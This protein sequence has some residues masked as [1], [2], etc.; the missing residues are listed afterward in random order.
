MSR[1]KS[2]KAACKAVAE[3]P[4][5]ARVPERPLRTND[6]DCWLS[7]TNPLVGVSIRTAQAIFDAARAGDT[8]RL[9]WLYQEIEAKDPVLMTC[10]ERRSAAIA[11]FTWNVS[12][13][14][15]A[16]KVLADEQQSA[17]LELIGNITNF[18]ELLEHLDS[19]F[20]RGFALAQ[21]VWADDGKTLDMV[22]IHDSWEFLKKD[23]VLYWNPG[24]NGFGRD[25]VDCR[26]AGLIGVERNRAIDYPALAIYLRHAVSERDWGRF[27][28]RYALPKPAVT[29][30]PNATNAQRNDYL[31]A[32]RAVENGQVS[33][34]PSGSTI[35]D[36][37]GGSR[38]VDPFQ[39]FIRHQEELI[40]LLATG[41]TLTSL[42][43][44]D[45]G[46]LA[47]GAQMEVWKQIVNRDAGVLS[48]AV[49]LAIVRPFLERNFWG[50][51]VAADFGLTMPFKMTPQEAANVAATLKQAGWRVDQ[52]ELEKAVGFTLEREET[53]PQ[54]PMPGFGAA[55]KIVAAK[56][57][58]A[59]DVNA[60]IAEKDNVGL[61]EAF[62]ADMSPAADA[63]THLLNN[64]TKEA[65]EELIGK[66]GDLM[67]DDPAMAAILAEAMANEFVKEATHE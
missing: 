53:Q 63:I 6:A 15:N 41:G 60:R 65:A 16:D 49:Q 2:L 56:H 7:R 45:T 8:Q 28:E 11:N 27:L 30:A 31:V 61:L 23:G 1:K 24:C 52:D 58:N 37:A 5:P 32:A 19:S 40:V 57:P 64:P 48:Q 4:V 17:A 59:D 29:M 12:A 10:I 22:E 42:A 20:F 43:T 3:K 47:G 26:D 50:R 39:N 38:G 34:W 66:I 18:T 13:R 62:A 21:P 9:H 44:A 25:A 35:A 46:A 67:P 36:F 54:L 51:P 14:P 55:R 33:V